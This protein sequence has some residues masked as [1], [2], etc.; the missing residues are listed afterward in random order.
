MSTN[1]VQIIVRQ[2]RA[3]SRQLASAAD[4]TRNLALANISTDKPHVRGPVGPDEL[5]TYKWVAYGDG[6]LRS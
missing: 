1:A 3:A 6:H 5:T 2:S 4:S